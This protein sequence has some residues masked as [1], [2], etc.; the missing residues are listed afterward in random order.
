MILIVS[1]EDD[2]GA[3]S[4]A[5]QWGDIARVLTCA[6][7]ARG[8]TAI[9]HPRI[10]DSIL[11]V[12]GCLVSV[13]DITGVLNLLPAVTAADVTFYPPEERAYQAAEF[14]ALWVYLLSAL[15]CPVINRPT[16]LSLNGPVF[17]RLGWY[18]LA[19]RLGIPLA[20]LTS[21][22]DQVTR[23]WDIDPAELIEVTSLAG[24]I[25]RSSD[26]VA[27]QYVGAMAA[28]ANLQYMTARF[29]MQDATRLRFVAAQCI[30]DA[31][32]PWIAAALLQLFQS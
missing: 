29:W 15:P 7:I 26:T 14:H 2:A 17:N 5:K 11:T 25:V 27:D 21:A 20:P 31:N 19:D 23:A 18:H 16:P 4:L 13:S 24:R 10:G 28:A 32:S 6:D 9:F 8:H 12:D 22:P 3:R 1:R 30:P